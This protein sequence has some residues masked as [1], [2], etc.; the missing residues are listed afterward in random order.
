M[1]LVGESTVAALSWDAVA[2]GQLVRAGFW[3]TRWSP[4][5]LNRLFRRCRQLL[6]KR[7]AST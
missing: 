7:P 2:I 4:G 3:R 1:Q 5:F 6:S